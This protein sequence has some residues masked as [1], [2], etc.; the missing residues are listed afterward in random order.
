MKLRSMILAAA[1]GIS[2]VA[3]AVPMSTADAA[4]ASIENDKDHELSDLALF[5]IGVAGL[6]AGRRTIRK[7]RG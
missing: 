1:L 2:P 6:V 3:A 5:A 4:M 7:R